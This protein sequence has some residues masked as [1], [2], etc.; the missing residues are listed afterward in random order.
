MIHCLYLLFDHLLFCYSRLL[1]F[2]K[3][4]DRNARIQLCNSFLCKFS[5]HQT[6][7][8]LSFHIICLPRLSH[9]SVRFFLRIATAKK[10]GRAATTTWKRTRQAKLGS[11][12]VPGFISQGLPPHSMFDV[13]DVVW[14]MCKTK[15]IY[16]TGPIRYSLKFH[17]S[18]LKPDVIVLFPPPKPSFL[19]LSPPL[20]QTPAK[21]LSSSVTPSTFSRHVVSRR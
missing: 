12:R 13:L 17:R 1:S 7:A 4:G 2:M 15:N 8:G 14:E 19:T 16:S 11:L 9:H 10:D 5:Q 18:N 3:F 21:I 6:F 20:L